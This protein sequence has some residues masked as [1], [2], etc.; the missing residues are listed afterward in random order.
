MKSE[1]D[2]DRVCEQFVDYFKPFIML[3]LNK[4][5]SEAELH[6]LKAKLQLFIETNNHQIEYMDIYT[7]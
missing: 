4:H 5:I 7:Q 2:I 6:R 1:Y 3:K